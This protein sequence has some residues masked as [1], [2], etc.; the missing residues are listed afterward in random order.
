MIKKIK[1]DLIKEAFKIKGEG[2]TFDFLSNLEFI[3][4]KKGKEGVRKV[5]DFFKSLGI[6][7]EK[8][9]RKVIFPLSLR[10]VLFYFLTDSFGFKKEDI[11]EM[12][13]YSLKK[14]F[15]LKL[16]SKFFFSPSKF[17]LEKVPF[18]WKKYISVG[19][20]ISE[21]FDSTNQKAILILKGIDIPSK[22]LEELGIAY[23]QGIFRGWVEIIT[24]SEKV[25]CFGEKVSD[26]KYKFFITWK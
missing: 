24:G 19:E 7:L 5:I 16:Y 8:E 26:K 15:L 25:S 22:K 12:G 2:K 11:E 9:E 13:R 14:S 18:L 17:F 6:S 4:K 3:K 21:K 10:F 23:L 1:E 20:V